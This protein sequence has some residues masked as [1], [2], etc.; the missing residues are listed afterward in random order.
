MEY[1]LANT[2]TSFIDKAREKFP[3]LFHQAMSAL[4]KRAVKK[5]I[6]CSQPSPLYIVV[7]E[8]KDY[9]VEINVER[10]VKYSCSCPDFQYNITPALFKEEKGEIRPLCYHILAVMLSQISELAYHTKG[11]FEFFRKKEMLPEIFME[12]KEFLKLLVQSF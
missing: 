4:K 9:L 2:L 1:I 12:E 8:N 10:H 11:S 6:S 7:G 3:D 5:Y